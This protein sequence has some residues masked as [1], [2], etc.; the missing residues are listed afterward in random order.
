MNRASKGERTE[1]R[2]R[3][4]ERERAVRAER[5]KTQGASKGALKVQSQ[6]E[7]ASACMQCTSNFISA[8]IMTFEISMEPKG[9]ITETAEHVMKFEK[10]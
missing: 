4:G 10:R 9:D 7:G 3:E 2:E 5:T 8:K 6:S 1:E